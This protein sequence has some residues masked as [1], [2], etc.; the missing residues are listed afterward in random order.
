M[1]ADIDHTTDVQYGG[2]TA[3]G[4]LAHLCR[5]HHTLK[6]KTNWS[7][8]RPPAVAPDATPRWTSPLGFS[9]PADPAPF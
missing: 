2:I 6:H 4:N 5:R 1:N 9:R 8:V 3:N 7:Y